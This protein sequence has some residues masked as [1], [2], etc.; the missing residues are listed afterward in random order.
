MV[1]RRRRDGV[2][3]FAEGGVAAAEDHANGV[4]AG[5][6]EG[7]VGLFADGGEEIVGNAAEN[8]RAVAGDFV[9]AGCAAVAEV[10]EDLLAVFDD[11]VIALAGDVN[12]GA[13]SACVVFVLRVIETVFFGSRSH[14]H[15][16]LENTGWP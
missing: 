8:A 12:D 16:L 5:R 15:L 1:A 10:E 6:A 14:S 2:A 4:R 9:C 11:A 3:L 13:D 7:D